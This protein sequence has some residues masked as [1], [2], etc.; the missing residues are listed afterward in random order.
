MTEKSHVPKNG[1]CCFCTD[2]KGDLGFVYNEGSG[3]W[4]LTKALRFE[5]GCTIPSEIYGYPVM[6]IGER[7]FTECEG[8][9]NI[10]ISN[11]IVKIG[12]SAF[13]GC[14]T[15]TRVIMDASVESIG[16]RAFAGCTGLENVYMGSYINSVGAD[17]FKGCENIKKVN[18]SNMEQWAKVK[19]ENKEANPFHAGAALY[20]NG[21]EV[22]RSLINPAYGHLFGQKSGID[23]VLEEASRV[24]A[25]IQ[26]AGI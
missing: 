25:G 8:L 7:A 11:D 21:K 24:A 12:D 16:K 15:L 10:A 6:Q 22:D 20:S 1:D 4:T 2:E 9:K 23:N 17:A 3:G 18:I 14:K 5:D 26:N 13:E 19:F